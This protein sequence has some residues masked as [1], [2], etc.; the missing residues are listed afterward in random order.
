M[1]TTNQNTVSTHTIIETIK[2]E[3]VK[4][5]TAWRAIAEQFAIAYNQ[6][7][8][9]SDAYKS[10][11]K[12]TGFHSSTAYKLAQIGG[13][14]RLSDPAFER[15][16]AWTVLYEI[17]RM[18][19][20]EIETLKYRLG[21]MHGYTGTPTASMVKKIRFPEPKK[22]D[23]YQSAFNIRIDKNALKGG[24]FDGDAYESLVDLVAQIQNTVP[25]VRVDMTNVYENDVS[26]SMSEIA[27]KRDVIAREK[28]REAIKSYKERS[29]DWQNYRADKSG[30]V[31]RPLIGKYGS[32]EELWA[33]F[34]EN[35]PF[36]ILIE[37]GAGND[38]LTEADLWNEAQD[39]VAASRSERFGQKVANDQFA[40]ANTISSSTADFEVSEVLEKKNKKEAA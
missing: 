18:T 11:L 31:K 35:G 24:L 6:Y 15:V 1:T 29:L 22:V 40:Y 28:V 13:D 27:R 4:Q 20:E 14:A 34:A 36:D 16:S 32:D 9:D 12:A 33:Y 19:N 23:P 39:R 38:E 37:L 3:M 5:T 17:S 8:S 2:E 26:Q 25:Y 21:R 30:S 7:G 10:I